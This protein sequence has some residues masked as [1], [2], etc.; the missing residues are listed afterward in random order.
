MDFLERVQDYTQLR[1]LPA[2]LSVAFVL[3]SLYSFGGISQFSLDW[4]GYE[5]QKSD[6]THVSLIVL[7]VAF[8][9]SETRDYTE[10]QLWEQVAIAAS[11]VIIMTHQ[12]LTTVE[13]FINSNQPEAGLIAFGITL[14][15]W[16]VA[17]R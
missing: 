2:L 16:G 5:I 10:Y 14:F 6:A 12:Y 4:V 3:S 8:A 15:S 1:T 9:S 7:L 13:Q 11:P 17:V